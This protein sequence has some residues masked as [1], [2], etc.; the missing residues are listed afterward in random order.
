MNSIILYITL[1][2]NSLNSVFVPFFASY[3]GTGS[4]LYRVRFSFYVS[5]H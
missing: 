1:L 2:C 5:T 3:E 4:V